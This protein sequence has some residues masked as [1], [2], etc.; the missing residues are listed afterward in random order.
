[1]NK[2]E[3]VIIVDAALLQDEKEKIIKEVSDIISKCEG[4]VINSQIWFEKQKLAFRMK[5]KTEGTYYIIN[6]EGKHSELAKQR[7][8]IKLNEKVLR[9]LIIKVE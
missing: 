4:K 9:S 6:F 1:M 7:Q 5:K 2:Y 3:M 8:L